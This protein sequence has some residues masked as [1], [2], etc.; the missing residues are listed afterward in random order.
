LGI[1]ATTAV[2]SVIY[3]IVMNPY[4]YAHSDRMV[5]MRLKDASG[6]DRFFGLTA[7]QWQQIR[8]SPVVEDAF[9]EGGWSL[10]VTGQDL[11]EDVQACVMS[12]NSFE[13]LGV[14]TFLGR[15]LLPSD[16]IDGHDPEAVAVLGYKF[17][18]KHFNSNREVVGQKLQLV[19]KN[20]TIVGVAAPRFTWE[21]A[22]VYLPQKITQDLALTYYVGLRIKPGITHEAANAALTP[23]IEQFAKQTPKHFPAEKFAFHVTGLNEDFMHDLGGTLS[24]LFTGVALLL[25]IGCGNVS[26]L[27]LARGTARQQEFAVRSAIGASRRRLI[28]QLLTEAVLLSVTGAALG[29]LLAYKA[30]DVMV[31]MLPKYSFPHEA[32]IGIDLPVLIFSV[33]VAIGTGIFFGLWPALQLSRPDLSQVI[34]SGSRRISGDV[35]GRFTNNVLIAGQIA[36][37]LV[38]L[39][40]AGA[41]MEGFLRLMHTPLG[42]DPHNVMSVG[43]PVHENT[44]KTWAER[45]AYFE[46]LRDNAGTVPGVSM[47]AISS[48]ATPPSNGNPSTVEIMGKGGPDDQKVRINFVSPNYFPVLRIPLLRGRVWDETENHNAAHMAVINETMAKRY[49]PNGDAVGHSFRVPEMRDEPPLSLAAPDA[50]GWM[51]IVGVIADKRDDGLRKPIVPEAFLP[52]TISMHMWTQILVR[53]EVSPLT[54]VHAIG[55]KVN[56]L[57]ADQ[58]INGHIDDLDHWITNQQ[59][60]EQEHFVAWLF[61]AFAVL[62]LALASVGLYSVVSYSVAQRTSEFGI[63]MALGA[64]RSH[65]WQIVFASMTVSVGAGIFGGVVLTLALN[66]VLARWAEGSARDP[67]VLVG[68]VALLVLVAAVACAG[69]ARRAS[70]IDPITAL[71]FE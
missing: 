33:V 65:V 57:D 16:A 60:Y 58:Q 7:G 28:R 46:R 10:T 25:A 9:L 44:Y 71:H 5:H 59:E 34:Q 38:M 14:P 24:L 12:S 18:Q 52:F 32:A 61:G 17:W 68:V 53:S 2:F 35:R 19:K 36:L 37:T 50:A 69:P 6:Q 23:L 3:A 39:T 62:A 43:I 4:P 42:Y 20:Y 30:L 22:D 63:R 27:L 64:P 26:I 49:F 47:V 1:G 67:L 56:A 15:G 66:R 51:Q 45:S 31:A 8:K 41:A 54:L 29:V 55:L 21:D 11:P 40:V 48:N 13:F 70:D